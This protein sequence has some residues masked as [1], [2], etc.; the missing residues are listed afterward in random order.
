MGG[1]FRLA[2][3]VAVLA[4]ATDLGLGLPMEHA[5]RAC[6]LG[7]EIGRRAGLGRQEL[8]DLYYLTL[9]RV[10]S[11]LRLGVPLIVFIFLGNPLGNYLGDLGSRGHPS[12]AHYLSVG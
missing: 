2:E 7:T 4:M 5:V 10:M 1:R 11:P 6:L 9:L 3:V 12:L 8:G